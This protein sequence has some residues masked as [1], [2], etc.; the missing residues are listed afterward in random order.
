VRVGAYRLDQKPMALLQQ[1]GLVDRHGRSVPARQM[2]MLKR[3]ELAAFC[4]ATGMSTQD[5]D[6]LSFRP[7]VNSY[8]PVTEAFLGM[9]GLPPLQPRRLSRLA[10]DDVNTLL[11]RI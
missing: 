4:P 6:A 7:H 9:R 8:P 3:D 2:F 5:A 1:T 11:L 10:A